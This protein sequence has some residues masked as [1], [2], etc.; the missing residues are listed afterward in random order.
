MKEESEGLKDTSE[1]A[2]ISSTLKS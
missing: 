2:I 1:G